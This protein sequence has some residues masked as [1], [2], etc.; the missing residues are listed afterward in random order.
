MAGVDT[1]E[2]AAEI[3]AA[4]L[5]PIDADTPAEKGYLTMLA[6]R[7][8]LRRPGFVTGAFAIL[9]SNAYFLRMARPGAIVPLL[10]MVT[11]SI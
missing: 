8:G 1:P 5:V 11:E 6:G 4:S 2:H 9:A 7:L 3:Y 10:A